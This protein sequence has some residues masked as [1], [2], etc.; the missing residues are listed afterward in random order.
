MT[1][2]DKAIIADLQRFRA[3]T[4]EQISALHFS[5]CKNATK[6]ANS[7]LL[8]LRR[9]GHISASKE[10]RMYTYFPSKSIKKDSSK[11]NHF[12]AIADFY[13]EISK[14][15]KIKRFDVEPKIGGKGYPE[16]DVFMIWRG[17]PFFIEVQMS[18]Y[19]SKQWLEKLNRYE[20]YYHTN[21]WQK[22]DWQPKDKKVLPMI[23]VC[24]KGPGM[25]QGTSFRVFHST[26]EEM[27]NRLN[28]K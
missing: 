17:T 27:V 21:D 20:Q 10:R 25:I 24:G 26:V 2:R 19:S 3:M 4:R 16:P 5:S 28:K 22:L 23:W 1:S 7:V 15:D 13:C 8:R 11:L 9:D 6:E 14:H 18:D 12:L